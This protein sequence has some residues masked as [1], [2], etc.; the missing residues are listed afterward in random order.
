MSLIYDEIKRG[1]PGTFDKFERVYNELM[2]TGS[3]VV[4]LACTELSVFKKRNKIYETC[5]D[6]LDILVRESIQRSNAE[7]Q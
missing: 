6:A 5:L 7:Y 4:L 3:D 1:I 2:E